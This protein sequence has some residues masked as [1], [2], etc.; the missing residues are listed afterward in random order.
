MNR[1]QIGASLVMVAVSAVILAAS[2]RMTYSTDFG[3]GP[4]FFPFWASAFMLVSS[5]WQLLS[6]LRQ[7]RLGIKAGRTE[8]PDA[9]GWSKVLSILA[10]L[11]GAAL[12]FDHLGFH[13]TLAL[14]MAYLL[15]LVERQGLVR[16]LAVL[17]VV[18]AGFWLLFDLLLQLNF[19]PGILGI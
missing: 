17:L 10:G 19:P 7:A 11:V 15:L 5:G 12:L 4:G 3:P 8:W 18:L 1:S 9:R 14:L 16:S 6:Q 13:L 2:T